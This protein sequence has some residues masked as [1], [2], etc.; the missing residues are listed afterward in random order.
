MNTAIRVHLVLVLTLSACSTESADDPCIGMRRLASNRIALNRLASNR[1]ASNR[2]ASNG[3][4]DNALSTE[5]LRGD[6]APAEDLR[7]PELRDV[8]AYTVQCALA[9]RQSV[10][11]TIDG[12]VVTFEGA[13]GLAPEWGAAGGSCDAECIGWVS[14]C[15][16]SRVN[17]KGESVV[18]SL[19]GDHPGLLPSDD[20]LATY[21]AV[22]ATYFGN[23][24]GDAKRM[25]A[26][27]PDG[28]TA[29][30]RVCGDDSECLVQIEGACSDVC[31][32][33]TCRAGD[34]TVFAQT[35]T[36]QRDAAACGS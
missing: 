6:G 8:F 11:V 15:L 22:E 20:E 21:D 24:F 35:I 33:S 7:D 23:V 16:I 19:R 10:D 28:A 4:L 25:H 1:L 18:I 14:A 9:P 17:A 27:V 12:E 32:G 30:P 36:V 26:C 29:I 3:L 2:L 5:A 34:G 31:D 13:L